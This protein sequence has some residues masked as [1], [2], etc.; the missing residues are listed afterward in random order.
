MVKWKKYP[1][2]TNYLLDLRVK[3]NTNFAPV[4]VSLQGSM[5]Q[6]EVNGL[7]PGTEY[8]VTLKSFH[9]Y[10][11]MCMDTDVAGTGKEYS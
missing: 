10:F 3:N 6:M 8:N 5:T 7:H 1:G 4:V 2:A 11:V 9:F